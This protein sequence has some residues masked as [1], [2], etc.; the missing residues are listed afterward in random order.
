MTSP[1]VKVSPCDMVFMGVYTTDV[2]S[3]YIVISKGFT[4]ERVICKIFKLHTPLCCRIILYMM[5]S[6]KITSSLK[7]YLAWN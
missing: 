2:I 7:I 4:S 3:W 5:K 6:I 1:L